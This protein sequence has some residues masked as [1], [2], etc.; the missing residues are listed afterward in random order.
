[1]KNIRTNI[2]WVF[3]VIVAIL[4]ATIN[5]AVFE[6]IKT[7]TKVSVEGTEYAEREEYL[8]TDTF[9]SSNDILTQYFLPTKSYI[10]DLKI[11]LTVSDTNHSS[12]WGLALRIYE[13]SSDLLVYDEK[14]STSDFKNWEYYTMDVNKTVKTGTLYRLEVQQLTGMSEN[15]LWSTSVVCFIS[16]YDLQEFDHCTFNGENIEGNIE[17]IFQYS[18][19]DWDK[20]KIIIYLDILILMCFIIFHFVSKKIRNTKAN[21]LV[22]IILWLLTPVVLFIFVETLIG[23]ILSMSSGN[24]LINVFIYFYI[25][26]MLTLLFRKFKF[27]SFF[28]SGSMIVLALVQYYVSQFRGKPFTLFDVMSWNT[29]LTV[30]GTYTYN[31]SVVA[32]VSLLCIIIF[33]LLQFYFQN[34]TWHSKTEK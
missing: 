17:L 12:D 29:A 18:Y 1:M 21:Y 4:T 30:A 15:E 23:N 14:I 9:T 8:F 13:D 22:G 5:I 31:I 27:A 34:L 24:V 2:N 32:G 7:E 6:S 11:R 33:L 16:P 25:F 28:F 19:H 10:D 3:A 26:I 20:M